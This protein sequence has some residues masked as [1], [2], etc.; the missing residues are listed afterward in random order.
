MVS[1]AICL[2]W[3]SELRGQ[4]HCSLSRE[5]WCSGEIHLNLSVAQSHTPHF[6]TRLVFEDERC[7]E[8]MKVIS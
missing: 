8:C 4:L 3:L 2:W 5:D 7:L 6:W 1:A